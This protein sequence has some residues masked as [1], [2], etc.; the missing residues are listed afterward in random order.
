MLGRF[1][2]NP[3]TR[4]HE[5]CSRPDLEPTGDHFWHC[6]QLYE[7]PTFLADTVAKYAAQGFAMNEAVVIV[8]KDDHRALFESGL[9]RLGADVSALQSSGQLTFLSAEQTL[10]HFVVAGWPDQ[11][12][13]NHV[14]GGLIARLS[15]AQWSGIRAFGEMVAVLWEGGH[16]A[17]ALRL[18]QFW[19]DLAQTNKF[20]LLCA[21]AL[22]SF[23]GANHTDNFRGICSS[24]SLV[25]PSESYL[26]LTNE[27]DRLRAVAKLQQIVASTLPPDNHSTDPNREEQDAL[28]SLPTGKQLDRL[29]KQAFFRSDAASL[30]GVIAI[31][32]DDWKRLNVDLGRAAGDQILVEASQ[33]LK[34]CG[35]EEG[36]KKTLLRTGSAEFIMI[37]ESLPDLKTVRALSAALSA[38]FVEPL[39]IADCELHISVSIGVSVSAPQTTDSLELQQNAGIALWQARQQ[40]RG[41]IEFYSARLR[42]AAQLRESLEAGLRNAIARDELQVYFQ[43]E[44]NLRNSAITRFEA[45]LRWFPSLD[46]S[47][48]PSTFIPIAEETGM[49]I[50]VGNWVLEQACRKAA[51]WQ[52]GRLAGVGVAVNISALQFALPDFVAVVK[53]TLQD[54]GLSPRLLEL[55]VTETLLIRDLQHAT[56]TLAQLARLGVTVAIDDFGTNAAPLDYLHH[57]P[58]N[59]LKIDKSLVADLADS[60]SKALALRGL[61]ALGHDRGIRVVAEGV[62]TAEQYEAIIRSGCD[63]AQGFLLG[64]PDAEIGPLSLHLAPNPAATSA[65]HELFAPSVQ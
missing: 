60:A 18:E 48:P 44:V 15:A 49:I 62:E 25:L 29:L 1:R 59:A 4:S 40:G 3:P 63:E 52:N 32:L 6:V 36:G 43:P 58:I 57:L 31:G 26:S 61:I 14:I 27:E 45:L 7:H 50:H 12:V 9:A 51:A 11:A 55:E 10:A 20:S 8:A 21:Y 5:P 34:S 35:S 47:V 22:N 30:I 13:F 41:H 53:K 56:R 42:K 23:R 17:M 2:A 19:E 39:A 65:A 46:C 38:C 33:R 24:H 16:P 64:R 54:S 28:T 37:A